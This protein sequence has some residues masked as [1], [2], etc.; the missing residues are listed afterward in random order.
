MRHFSYLFLTLLAGGLIMASC[1]R[2]TT[3]DSR[4]DAVTIR[5]ELRGGVIPFDASTKAD[6]DG[7]FEFSS[8]NAMF[9]RLSRTVV[10]RATYNPDD[11]YWTFTLSS[12]TLDDLGGDGSEGDIRVGGAYLFENEWSYQGPNNGN[13]NNDALALSYRT[14]VY[15]GEGTF[16]VEGTSVSEL[17]LIVNATFKPLT[18]RITFTEDIADGYSREVYDVGG[19][20]YFT[21]FDYRNWTFTTSDREFCCGTMD[22]RSFIYGSFSSSISPFITYRPNG[23]VGI[24]IQHFPATLFQQGQSGSITLPYDYD[25]RNGW[26]MYNR[27][28][29]FYADYD[30]ITCYF[31][32]AGGFMMGGEDAL[33]VHEV[34]FADGFYMMHRE[35]TQGLW[36]YAMQNDEYGW[37][38][39]AV[40]GKT[41]DEIQ[42]FI[43]KLNERTG[44]NFRLP[45]EAEWE[46]AARG[47]R[48]MQDS[49]YSGSDDLQSVARRESDDAWDEENPF[50]YWIR[51]K[52]SNAIG[53]CDM[54][55]NVAEMCSDWYAEYPYGPVL[56]PKGPDTG[57]YHVVRGG[58]AFSSP[59]WMTCTHRGSEADYPS[60]QT[61]FRLVMTVTPFTN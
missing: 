48:W 24:L 5:M 26:L 3:P 29:N 34:T 4:N 22:K 45:T 41:Y 35:V 40:T 36:R 39:I 37:D 47:G 30:W 7:N 49:R 44:Y 14:P 46:Y 18:G 17:T 61:G 50:V 8:S 27:Y 59:E 12:G 9:L 6:Q 60:D 33:P 19:I 1:N 58:S 15:Y 31:V 32:G 20:R 52:N 10:G 42:V 43:Q 28:Y 56:D 57:T 13:F 51:S 54:S 23:D 53:M 2:E 25:N 16:S 11:G 21:G 55:G 38:D